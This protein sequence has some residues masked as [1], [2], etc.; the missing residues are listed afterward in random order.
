MEPKKGLSYFAE[1]IGEALEKIETYGKFAIVIAGGLLLFFIATYIIFL[2]WVYYQMTG[3]SNGSIMTLLAI[4]V[5]CILIFLPLFLILEYGVEIL[6]FFLGK[7]DAEPDPAT[8]P[9]RVNPMSKFFSFFT[10]IGSELKRLTVFVG[11]NRLLKGS[12]IMVILLFVFFSTTPYFAGKWGGVRLDSDKYGLKT[13]LDTNGLWP[14]NYEFY[15]PFKG[16]GKMT[17]KER[18]EYNLRVAQENRKT[19]NWYN[20]W[21]GV[22]KDESQSEKNTKSA[23]NSETTNPY[24]KYEKPNLKEGDVY[25]NGTLQRKGKSVEFSEYEKSASLE[26][27]TEKVLPEMPKPNSIKTNG[28]RVLLN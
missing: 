25:I 13:I 18:A 11:E 16:N 17:E 12:L 21:H 28:N 3:I 26:S 6:K 22:P 5:E 10:V 8:A 27:G 2:F 19:S 23:K 20:F 1:L 9:A 24:F 4:T 15:N 14:G 7:K